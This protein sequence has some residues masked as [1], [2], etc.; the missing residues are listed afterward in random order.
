MKMNASHIKVKWP[1]DEDTGVI[2]KQNKCKASA[3]STSD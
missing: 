3:A 2:T 1:G